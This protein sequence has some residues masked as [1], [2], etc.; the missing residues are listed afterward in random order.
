ML[1]YLLLLLL[2]VAILYGPFLWIDYVDK[3]HGEILPNMPGNGAELAQHLIE[4]FGLTGVKVEMGKSGEDHFAPGSKTIRLD[5][6]N[7]NDK[8]LTAI[9]TAAHEVGHA[10]QYHRQEKL[11][12]WR[13]RMAPM[14]DTFQRMAQVALIAAPLLG[15]I[16]RSP[17]SVLI[18]I[19]IGIAI[20][21]STLIFHLLTLPMEWDASFGKALPILKEGNYVPEQH[22][23]AIRQVL[24]AAAMTYVA[25][26]LIDLISFWRWF[27]F[28]R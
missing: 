1:F 2:A 9:A 12:C 23:P 25:G 27:R 3:K 18:P 19:L 5:P 7:Y 24:K 17:H 11:I 13:T 8:S 26:A 10:I 14:L 4:R 22:L 6:K 20:M 28:L 16:T 15:F 21:F